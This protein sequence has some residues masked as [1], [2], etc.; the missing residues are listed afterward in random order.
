M[1]NAAKLQKIND[2]CKFFGK[3][4]ESPAIF[5]ADLPKFPAIFFADLPKFPAIFT[6]QVS[7]FSI[8]IVRQCI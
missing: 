5:F 6:L 1:K 2:L 8:A 7:T 4:P 3:N